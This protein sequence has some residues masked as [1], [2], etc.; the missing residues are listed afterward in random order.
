MFSSGLAKG[1]RKN[2]FAFLSADASQQVIN[3]D[4]SRLAALRK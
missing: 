3:D 2:N 1:S 4:A